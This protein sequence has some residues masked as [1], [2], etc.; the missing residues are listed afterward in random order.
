LVK[1]ESVK[2]VPNGRGTKLNVWFDFPYNMANYLFFSVK[3][4]LEKFLKNELEA[5]L[6]KHGIKNKFGDKR[7]L[8]RI[9]QRKGVN[10]GKLTSELKERVRV[11]IPTYYPPGSRF[12]VTISSPDRDAFVLASTSLWLAVTYGGFGFRARRGAG[13]LRITKV[14][15]GDKDI[16]KTLKGFLKTLE[17]ATPRDLKTVLWNEVLE[18]STGGMFGKTFG[19]HSQ[20]PSFPNLS[21]F[22][23]LVSKNPHRTFMDALESLQ[24]AYAGHYNRSRRM[25]EGGVRFEFSDRQFSHKAIE[26]L[27]GGE[28]YTEY[29]YYFGTPVI[30]ANYWGT[31][32]KGIGRENGKEK[33]FSRRASSV[34]LTVKK[35]NESY[36]PMVVIIPYQYLPMH[37]GEFIAE[38]KRKSK[39]NNE[40]AI[41]KIL[42][43]RGT[44]FTNEDF[45]DWITSDVVDE[46]KK[47]GFVE[48]Y[49]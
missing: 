2:V 6:N 3:M 14:S 43:S 5:V 12:Q 25:Y 27:K 40:K 39:R 45:V 19:Q 20:M 1:V 7:Q 29:R 22:Q 47:R 41:I 38:S 16:D 9:L 42:T 31:G 46:F 24:E 4:G 15:F 44:P 8:D 28:T 21:G 48:V 30:Y 34:I 11:R 37:R 35:I 13:S 33:E 49:P 10:L 23:I 32:V 18:E 26:T 17:T 36:Y